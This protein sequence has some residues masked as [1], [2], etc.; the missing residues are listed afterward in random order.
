MAALISRSLRG[1][2]QHVFASQLGGLMTHQMLPINRYLFTGEQPW[3]DMPN[4]SSALFTFYPARDGKYLT[5]GCTPEWKYWTT[6]CEVVERPDLEHDPRF[7]DSLGRREH[8]EELMAILRDAFGAKP[9]AEWLQRLAAA[10]VPSTPLQE[11][12]DL[13]DDPQVL[14]NEYIIEYDHPRAG[15]VREVGFPVLFGRDRPRLRRPAPDLGEHTEEV[16]AEFGFSPD[17]IFALGRDGI[18]RVSST[19]AGEAADDRVVDARAR[20][21]GDGRP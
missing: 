19:P 7:A 14:E 1:G 2:G 8:A 4:Q 6:V 20:A 16:L 15:R 3:R 21:R 10:K 9:R 18:I 12:S 5:L 17:E 11:Y 13:A